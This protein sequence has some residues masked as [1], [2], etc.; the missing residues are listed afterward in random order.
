MKL[1]AFS[2]LRDG[3]DMGGIVVDYAY[4]YG[5]KIKSAGLLEDDS[6]KNPRSP[7]TDFNAKLNLVRRTINM[8]LI[9]APLC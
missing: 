5:N 2:V 3:D 1:V 8:E 7:L 9:V 6:E 4:L